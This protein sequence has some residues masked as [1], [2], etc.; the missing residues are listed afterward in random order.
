MVGIWIRRQIGLSFTANRELTDDTVPRWYA[1]L[2][3][4]HP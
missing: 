1:I 3:V 4:D 2:P